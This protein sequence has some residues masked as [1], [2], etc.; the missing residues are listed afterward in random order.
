VPQQPRYE[1]DR[2]N[3]RDDLIRNEHE[4]QMMIMQQQDQQMDGVLHTVVNMKNIALTMNTELDD[5]SRLL[6]NLD[7]KVDTSGSRLKAA[8]TRL[9]NFIK[10]NSKDKTF[11]CIVLLSIVVV[12]LLITLFL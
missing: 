6:Q 12:I 4:Q 7:E 1:E 8:Q 9:N 11:W 5:Q 2:F 3:Y 10:V